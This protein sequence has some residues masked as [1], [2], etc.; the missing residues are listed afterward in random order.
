MIWR[1]C[2]PLPLGPQKKKKDFSVVWSF[3]RNSLVRNGIN[4]VKPVLKLLISGKMLNSLQFNYPNIHIKQRNWT[5]VCWYFGWIHK[6]KHWQSAQMRIHLRGWW[7]G[8]AWILFFCLFVCMNVVDTACWV[9]I[10]ASTFFGMVSKLADGFHCFIIVFYFLFCNVFL[11][12][13]LD[14]R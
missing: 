7:F 14:S 6:L 8:S 4:F 1:P 5:I 12:V 3:W 11:V 9:G 2:S 10:K 13:H